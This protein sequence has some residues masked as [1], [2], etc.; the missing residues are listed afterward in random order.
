MGEGRVGDAYDM[1][2]ITDQPDGLPHSPPAFQPDPSHKGGG[3]SCYR[4]VQKN[5]RLAMVQ[6][7]TPIALQY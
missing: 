2:N 6:A 1:R 5:V 4:H 3:G 7:T